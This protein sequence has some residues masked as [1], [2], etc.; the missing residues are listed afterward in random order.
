MIGHQIGQQQSKSTERD[1]G[2][3]PAE[4]RMPRIRGPGRANAADRKALWKGKNLR[5]ALEGRV[6]DLRFVWV[7][8]EKGRVENIYM[9]LKEM[10][11]QFYPSLK[12][13]IYNPRW[14]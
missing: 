5:A 1:L 8:G 12:W 6:L 14:I 4:S 13:D 9:G 3:A 7:C 11:S 2:G 10:K